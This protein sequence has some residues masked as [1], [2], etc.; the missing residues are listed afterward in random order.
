M[1]DCSQKLFTFGAQNVSTPM[2][3][4]LQKIFVLLLVVNFNQCCADTIDFWHIYI[5][6]NKKMECSNWSQCSLDVSSDSISQDDS[7]QIGFYSCGRSGSG[8]V[9]VQVSNE[10]T[11][12]IKLYDF[13]SISEWEA[14]KFNLY[15]LYLLG[16]SKS[17]LLTFSYQKTDAIKTYP[18]IALLELNFY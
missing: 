15:E 2:K 10:K 17:C 12:F 8:S 11:E 5:N 3:T 18:M 13:N 1:I 9:R 6:H 14:M 16:G 4:I 7:L